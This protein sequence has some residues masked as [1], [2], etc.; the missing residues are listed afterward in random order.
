MNIV[1]SGKLTLTLDEIVTTV[2]GYS[3]RSICKVDTKLEPKTKENQLYQVF[4][5]ANQFR[6]SNDAYKPDW[7]L[8]EYF[9]GRDIKTI[10]TVKPAKS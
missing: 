2:D 6:R 1:I 10:L 8:D 5:K 7:R 9:V 3:L 4:C